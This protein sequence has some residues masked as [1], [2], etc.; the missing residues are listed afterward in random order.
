MN[1]I[2]SAPATNSLLWTISCAMFIIN[3]PSELRSRDYFVLMMISTVGDCHFLRPVLRA[4]A[5]F[6]AGVHHSRFVG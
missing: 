6:S 5:L 4:C 2:Q 1:E 3:Y